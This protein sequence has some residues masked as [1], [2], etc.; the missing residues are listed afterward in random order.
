MGGVLKDAF[1]GAEVLYRVTD[2]G[3]WFGSFISLSH[4]TWLALR[5]K[6][7]LS[8]AMTADIEWNGQPIQ[9]IPS[10]S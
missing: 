3:P 5:Q 9:T 7:S 2:P 6:I 8:E 4:F 1:T 10:A